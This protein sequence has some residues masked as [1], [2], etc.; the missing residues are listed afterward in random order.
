MHCMWYRI[1]L[2]LD[3]IYSKLLYVSLGASGF[4]HWICVTMFCFFHSH[5]HRW[6]CDRGFRHRSAEVC[7]LSD[8]PKQ[9]IISA[10]FNSMLTPLYIGEIGAP[11]SRGALLALDQ[12]GIVRHT[13]LY[14]I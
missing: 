9:S 8:H 12:L 11:E 13:F 10:L 2:S 3:N 5:S 6:S 14:C 7:T 4:L 1:L